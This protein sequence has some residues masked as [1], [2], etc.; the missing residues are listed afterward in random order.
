MNA[1]IF[2]SLFLLDYVFLVFEAFLGD[3]LGEPDQADQVRDGHQAVHRVG[4]VPD[5]F[6]RRGRADEGDQRENH[7]VGHDR[8]AGA[9]QVFE[10]FLTVVFPAQDR[11]EREERQRHGND[12]RSRIAES[13]LERENGQVRA[14][15][16]LA[17]RRI[18]H[19]EG[20]GGRDD[21]TCQHADDHRVEESAGH[22]DIALTGRMVRAG[23]RSGD[24]RGAHAR[25]V[26][27][28]AAGD[29]PAHSRQ[30]R[31]DDGAADA[32]CNRF[33]REGHAENLGDAR[34]NGGNIRED[35]DD[36]RDEIKHRHERH[37][38]AGHL[39]DGVNAAHE[40][41]KRANHD[42]CAGY[43]RRDAE[44]RMDGRGDRMR[45]RHVADAE[46]REDREQREERRHDASEHAADAVLHRVHRAAGH[47]ADA[48]RLAVLDRQHR[49]AVFRRKP[50]QRADPHPDECARTAEDHRRRDADNIAGADGG[51]KRRHQRLE[52]RDVALVLL[53]FL[54]DHADG[55]EKIAPGQELQPD[56]QEYAGADE[57]RQHDRPPDKIVHIIQQL[58]NIHC[59]IQILS[60]ADPGMA[61]SAV[62]IGQGNPHPHNSI[63]TR[64][65][66]VKHKYENYKQFRKKLRIYI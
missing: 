41:Q 52:R 7:A 56:R 4:E 26:G 30:H 12:D 25:L 36:R 50:E 31:S 20:A 29:A 18:G 35:G 42:D 55:V 11:R 40:D 33:R 5:D 10:G 46:G 8:G 53:L 43:G 57:K 38:D 48:V 37:D 44:A 34:R 19:A 54:E 1:Y 28:D 17:G 51:G 63:E 27:E 15:N 16:Q 65:N 49:F 9:D 64:L 22:I 47:L 6:E 60:S 23:R 45:L 66:F 39:A 24:R 61:R 32:A 2:S 21:E 59:S 62:F 58:L 14:G 3:V 13:G